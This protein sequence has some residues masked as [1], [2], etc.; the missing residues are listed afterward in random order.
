M[1]RIT[2]STLIKEGTELFI[3]N[4]EEVEESVGEKLNPNYFMYRILEQKNMLFVYGAYYDDKLI[5]YSIMSI[6]ALP[7]YQHVKAAQNAV[8]YILPEHRGNVAKD[9]IKVCEDTAVT[10]FEVKRIHWHVKC[11]K[12]WSPVLLRKGYEKEEVIL[13]KKV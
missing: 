10:E 11:Q 2:M 3:K 9:L 5:G 1:K 12:D 8:I 6:L 4:S 13:V 7:H